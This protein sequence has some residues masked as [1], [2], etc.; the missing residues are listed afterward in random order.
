MILSQ[1]AIL[2]QIILAFVKLRNYMIKGDLRLFFANRC[3]T[4]YVN[5]KL[6]SVLKYGGSVAVGGVSGFFGGGGGMLAVPLLQFCG[7]DA[8][9]AHATALI[10]ILPI[11]IVSSIIYICGGYFEVQTAVSACIGVVMGGIIGAM[12]LDKLNATAIGVIFSLMMIAVGI[13]LVIL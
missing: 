13:K 3:K 7:L 5:T 1:N 8:K 10:V 4:I 9:R 11:C 6:G 12:L 2:N